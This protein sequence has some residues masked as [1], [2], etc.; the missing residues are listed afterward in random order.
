MDTYPKRPRYSS[1]HKK[2]LTGAI[3]ALSSALIAQANPPLS[4]RD[5]ET[6]VALADRL[7]L[8]RPGMEAMADA[9]AANDHHAVLNLFRAR[10]V[11][12]LRAIDF[13]EASVGTAA[14]RQYTADAEMLLGRMTPDDYKAKYHREWIDTFSR[15]T[16]E[17]FPILRDSGL[18]EPLGTPIQWLPEVRN[19]ESVTEISSRERVGWYIGAW[20][21]GG[22]GFNTSL[23]EAWWFSG[24][25]EYKEK[26]LEIAAGYFS[27]F[28]TAETRKALKKA[29]GGDS[30][31][32]FPLHTAWRMHRSFLPALALIAKH[33]D[34]E[35]KAPRFAQWRTN[36]P[37]DAVMKDRQA[38][39]GVA[40]AEVSAEQLE[41]IPAAPLARI[42]IGLTEE[43]AP[44]LI[45]A[46]ITG[47][48]FFA[49]QNYDGILAVAT[50]AL[51]FEDLKKSRELE[52]TVN[53]AF[54]DWAK[55][56]IYRDGGP[57]EQD[58]HYS[59]GYAAEFDRQANL[60]ASHGSKGEWINEFQ[61]LSLLAMN[62]WDQLQTPQGLLPCVGNSKYRAKAPRR[63]YPQ[64]S[65]YFPYSGY[66]GL[67][68]PGAPD[69]QLFMMFANSRRSKGHLSPNT[70]S[71]HITAYG[72]DLI[73]P[74]GSPSYGLT[75]PEQ[76]AE[77]AA[78]DNYAAEHSTYKNS[79]VIV[80]GLSQATFHRGR[81]LDWLEAAPDT[82]VPMRW[83]SNDTFDY[84][85]SKWVG[86]ERR[87]KNSPYAPVVEYDREIE[88]HRQVVF[89]KSAG[90]WLLVDLM[91]Y[92]PYLSVDDGREGDTTYLLRSAVETVSPY[93]FTQIWNFAPPRDEAR[94]HYGFSDEQVKID[95][96]QRR[97]FTDD[98]SGVNLELLHFGGM[99]LNYRKHF[100]HKDEKMYLGWLVGAGGGGTPRVDLHA[101]WEQTREDLLTGR[102]MPLVTVIAP[103]RDAQSV[104]AS[105]KPRVEQ[106][107]RVSGCEFTMQDGKT[108]TFLASA[109]PTE[110]SA[111]ELVAHAELLV[112]IGIP[113]EETQRG[114]L[115]GCT[116]MHIGK[117]H[118]ALQPVETPD[119]EF[120]FDGKNVTVLQAVA[121]PSGQPAVLSSGNGAE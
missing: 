45:E 41:A 36:W 62:F 10:V 38:A 63:A 54:P 47:D 81:F 39:N 43:T 72:R 9:I 96:A 90:L 68:T 46:Y 64:A 106:D 16:P 48:Y 82:P 118:D 87:Q 27:E 13:S 44:Y 17:H 34:H 53:K 58:F 99:P 15:I 3:L 75:P 51:I 11:K 73:A 59:I 49:N 115:L 74:G 84:V 69:E 116:G 95:E 67:R 76:K 79:T 97:V 52:A 110:L 113:G 21:G 55:R 80:N 7:D 23:V 6:A 114:I 40:E 20:G 50:I 88:H 93:T 91:G 98:P 70:G 4:E 35:S 89:I 18:M 25:K 30:G 61:R 100:G 77:E 22:W 5:V 26:W 12:R 71:I 2:L 1:I 28:F 108:I 86:Y 121:V 102:V 32:F 119:F 29:D 94:Q 78:F 57:L 117:Q 101:N 85:E 120:T 8:T 31:A 24:E 83:L 66:A 107:G 60:F 42:A 111:G 56:V 33:P 92:K 14:N 109:A 65:T 37:P 105:A 103:S 112:L 104:I 19:E